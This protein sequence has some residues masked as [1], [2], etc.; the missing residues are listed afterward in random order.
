MSNIGGCGPCGG[1]E[2]LQKLMMKIDSE[3]DRGRTASNSARDAMQGFSPAGVL[4]GIAQVVKAL[5]SIS[6]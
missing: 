4:G 3:K 1:N 6:G 5:G 2:M